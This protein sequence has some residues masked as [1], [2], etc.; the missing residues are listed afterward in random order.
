MAM[1]WRWWGRRVGHPRCGSLARTRY[2]QG[3]CDVSMF[4]RGLRLRDEGICA[5]LV[6]SVVVVVGVRGSFAGQYCRWLVRVQF[7]DSGALGGSSRGGEY[8]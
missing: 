2:F 1:R 8:L 6:L 3:S 7:G 5:A 4:T